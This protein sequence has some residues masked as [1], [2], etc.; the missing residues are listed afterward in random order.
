[1]MML[2]LLPVQA[3]AVEDH[4]ESVAD[5]VGVPADILYAMALA[6]SGRLVDGSFMPW[7]WTLNVEDEP[8][9]YD[10]REDMFKDLMRVLG[11]GKLRVDIGPMQTNWFWQFDKLKNPWRATHP[12]TNLK[13]AAELL[14][15]YYDEHGDWWVAVGLYHRPRQEESDQLIRDAYVARVRKHHQRAVKR[16]HQREGLALVGGAK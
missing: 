14:R 15:A 4:V 2:S 8:K 7:P 11:E 12:A 1:M 5:Y 10:S 16:A 6:E 9:R 3:W 13:I